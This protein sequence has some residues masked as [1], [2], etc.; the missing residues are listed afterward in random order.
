MLTVNRIQY[1]KKPGKLATIKAVKDPAVPRDDVYKSGTIH[2]GPGESPNSVSKPT[3]RG[4]QVA[5]KPITKGKLLRPGGPG[6]APSKLSGRQTQSRPIPQP[7][8]TRPAAAAQARPIPQPVAALSNGVGHGRTT[9]SS[10]ATA[11]ALPPPPPPPAAATPKEPTFKA[12]YEFNGQT[13]GELSMK[14]DEIVIIEKKE[15]NGT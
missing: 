12:L 5:A 8:T 3:P 1:N 7:V 15:G 2:T 10:S 11:R 4:K 9:S 13:A 14:K 6:G